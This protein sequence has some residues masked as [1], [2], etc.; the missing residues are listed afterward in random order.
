M[1]NIILVIILLAVAVYF[2]MQRFS[3]KSGTAQDGTYR[4]VMVDKKTGDITNI[5]GK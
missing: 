1:R 5:W 2:G 3:F 4:I